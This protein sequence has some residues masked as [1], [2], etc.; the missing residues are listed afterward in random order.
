MFLAWYSQLYISEWKILNICS[1]WSLLYWAW[2]SWCV[3]R[4]SCVLVYIIIMDFFTNWDI[5]PTPY[6]SRRV[7]TEQLL[8]LRSKI[9]L[10]RVDFP[11]LGSP[12]T[13]T[14]TTYW[15]KLVAEENCREVATEVLFKPAWI[16]WFLLSNSPTCFLSDNFASKKWHM[17]G[18][19]YTCTVTC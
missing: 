10:I 2:N 16:N 19:V 14:F 18:E 6:C 1:M 15:S 4:T 12:T 9:W 3:R 11:T 8:T 17:E 7:C 13:A 5:R